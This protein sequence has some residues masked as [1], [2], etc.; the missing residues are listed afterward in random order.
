MKEEIIKTPEYTK[1]EKISTI[2]EYQKQGYIFHGSPHDLDIIKLMPGK[3][4]D[5]TKIFNNDT[6]IFGS[7]NPQVCIFSLLNPDAVKEYESSVRWGT[8]ITVDN[9]ITARIPIS[10]KSLVENYTGFLYVLPVSSF[11][12]KY[13]WTVKS[14]EEIEPIDKI[15]VNFEDFISLGGKVEWKDNNI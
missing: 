12:E 2:R 14:Y 7:N 9:D 10:L 11:T 4:H 5:R 8:H 15:P 3:D 13:G 6:A 1:T